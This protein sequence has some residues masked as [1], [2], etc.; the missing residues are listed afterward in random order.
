[1]FERFFY[2]KVF[3]KRSFEGC[4]AAKSL[5]PSLLE[6]FLGCC[7]FKAELLGMLRSKIPFLKNGALRFEIKRRTASGC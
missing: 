5:C 7:I 4:C 1:L 6:H 3:S 2:F